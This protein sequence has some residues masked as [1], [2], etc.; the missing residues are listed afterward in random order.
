MDFET[1][2]RKYYALLAENE[3][4]KEENLALK[5]RLGLGEP[6]PET[7]HAPEA[8]QQQPLAPSPSA[9]I[10]VNTD[11]AEKILLFLSLFKGRE[12]VYAKRWETK[13]GT[14]A[15]YVPVCRNDGNFGVCRRFTVKCATCE[16]RSY[17]PLDENAID[18]HLRGKIVA[19]VYPLLQDETCHFLAIDFDKEGWKED[20]ST[21]RAVCCAFNI[22]V[23]LERSRSGQGAH[24]WFFF[25]TPVSAGMARKLGSAMLTYAMSQRHEIKF[26]SYDRLF[27]NQ[28]TMPKG[29]FGNLIA[30]PL[31]KEARLQSNSVFLDEHF[32][33]Y[34]DQ[35]EFLAK[36]RRLSE[37]EIGVLTWRLSPGSELG[38]LKLDDEEPARPWERK[39]PT[40]ARLTRQEF[41]TTVQV[42]RANMLF[43][44]K[45]GISQR[46]LNI[47]KRLAAFKNPEFYRLQAMRRPTW[48]EPPILSC[49]E[50]TPEYLCLP[51]G[52]DVDL[53]TM[54]K[55]A[56]VTIRWVD[57]SH[58]GRTIKVS[59]TGVLREDQEIAVEAMLQHDCGVLSAATAFGK[60]VVA[61][62]LIAERKVNTLILTHRQQLL[63]QWLARLARF[64]RIDEELPLIPTKRGRRPM[65]SIIGQIGAGKD[66]PNGIIDV[67][68]MQSLISG[69][70][71]KECVEDYGM[72]IVDECHH[73]SAVS[74]E[75]IVKRVRSKYV[76]G[77]TATPVRRDGR[78]PIIFMHCGPVRYRADAKKEAEKRPFDHYVIPRFTGYR[79]PFDRQE[80]DMSIQEFYSGMAADE[81]RNQQIIDDVIRA[82]ERGRNGLILTERTAHVELLTGRLR[83]RIP[84]V[85]AL[86]GGKGVKEA[87]N[88]LSKIADTPA[89]S[90]LTLVAT[91][92]Y[93]G[94]GFDEPR[95]DT[96]FLAM[97]I[98]WKGTLQQYAGRLHRLFEDKK[99]VHVYDYVD[100]HVSL[101]EKM[102]RK[103][104]SGY[105]AIGYRA[106]ADIVAEKPADIIFDNT[107]FLPVYQNDMMNCVRQMVIVSPFVTNRRVSRM[108]PE[109]AALAKRVSV[110]VVTR[111]ADTYKQK[112][113]PVLE[114]TLSSLENAGVRLLFRANIHQKFAV[115]DQKIVWYGS[116]N[117]LSY[118]SAQESIM[119]LDSSN[120]AQE[121][122]KDIVKSIDALVHR[123]NQNG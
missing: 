64:L 79:A 122:M 49:S 70:E 39:N 102:Y 97:P 12:D 8:M 50:E 80:Q 42:V 54:L 86:T 44:D 95:L 120:I 5:A 82:Y 108:L 101:L 77:L 60:T 23:A 30:L 81:S 4:L 40:R 61:A 117:L 123:E 91:G 48:R 68:I 104:L 52:C 21:L 11:P 15:G 84:D 38:D 41:P 19:G 92:R 59:F 73:I 94:E 72:V 112:D 96:L 35:W 6:A 18:A 98:S 53:E 78:H 27:P 2:L 74:F 118:G 28:A 115:L 106:K 69:H 51:R 88:I 13:D 116:I 114:A 89:S 7:H 43:I 71:A 36:I 90:Q 1:L 24:A 65:R 87:R 119:R 31:Q 111:P 99:E 17:A 26:K 45:S 33:P 62:R 113:M 83:E 93:I 46:A 37:E 9:D 16:H 22:P 107:N 121:L 63:S 103:R 67:G 34:E 110:I 29:G 109:M 85:I 105:G 76:C 58:P 25:A 14:R 75:Q 100:I 10:N 47:I 66:N 20:A 55:E 3:A 32:R 56:G 57:K